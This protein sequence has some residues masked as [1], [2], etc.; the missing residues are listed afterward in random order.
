M[1]ACTVFPRCWLGLAWPIPDLGADPQ[2]PKITCTCKSL[3]VYITGKNNTMATPTVLHGS[4]LLILPY[5][6]SLP[7]Q[8]VPR[9]PLSGTDM[10]CLP[11]PPPPPC[12]SACLSVYSLVHVPDMSGCGP[13]LYPGM[14]IGVFSDTI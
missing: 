6:M 14:K 8:L 5:Y 2:S 12:M 1:E 7:R 10:T 13:S 9:T 4:G 11:T 3:Q